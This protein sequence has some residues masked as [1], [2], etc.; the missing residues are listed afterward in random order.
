MV[1]TIDTF[2]ICYKNMLW[3]SSEVPQ[4]GTS[5]EYPQRMFLNLLVK[6]FQQQFQKQ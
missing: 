6:E 2:L 4:W 3:Y 5:D 1:Q